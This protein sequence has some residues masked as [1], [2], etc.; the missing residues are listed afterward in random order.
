M[1]IAVLIKQVPVSNDVPLIRKPTL[2]FVQVRK[3]M[4][5]PGFER[6]RGGNDLKRADRKEK[7]KYLRWDLR[8]QRR[9]FGDAM[10]MGCDESCLITDRCLAG[11]DTIATAKVL[12]EALRNLENLT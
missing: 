10:A 5:N 4:I 8:T 2:C 7:S 12:P 6:H 3:E 1:N 9:L 11:G